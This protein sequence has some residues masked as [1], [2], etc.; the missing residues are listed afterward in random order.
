MDVIML[1]AAGFEN[2]VATLGT[3]ITPDHAR[4]MRKYTSSVVIAYDS[5][6]A[7]QKAADKAL[8]LL[9]EA[10]IDAKVLRMTGAKDPDEF[11]KT[12][13]AKKFSDLLG[14]SR[15]R[16]D[17]KMENIL[18]AHDIA[19][20]SEKIKAAQEICAEIASVSSGVEREVYTERA[21]KALGVDPKSIKTDVSSMINKRL[22]QTKK[23]RPGELYRAGMGIS[24]RVN[25]DFAKRPIAARREETVLGLLLLRREYLRHPVSGRP[26]E[27]ADFCTDLGRRI[28]EAILA[29]EDAGGFDIGM[30]SETLTQEEVSRAT[31]MYTDRQ[32]LTDNGPPVFEEALSSLRAENEKNASAESGDWLAGLRKKQDAFGASSGGQD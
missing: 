32:K 14:D 12:F 31:R 27:S 9:G 13:G 29:G 25:P 15:T 11:I 16:F 23:A 17:Y 24:D 30:L 5:D 20:P 18:A 10:G 3:A 1:H 22:R 7:G 28:Y 26:V 19:D 2:A 6:G 4:I 21:A 8:R